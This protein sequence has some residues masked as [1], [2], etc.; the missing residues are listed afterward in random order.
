MN[1]TLVK[2]LDFVSLALLPVGLIPLETP[3]I[4]FLTYLAGALALAAF[5]WIVIRGRR[6]M[7]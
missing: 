2:V 4:G 5:V 3:S 1:P 7:T 6:W